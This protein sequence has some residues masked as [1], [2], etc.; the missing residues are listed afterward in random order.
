MNEYEHFFILVNPVP[1]N[2]HSS[3]IHVSLQ[4]GKGETVEEI[5]ENALLSD[6]NFRDLSGLYIGLNTAEKHGIKKVTV[7]TNN[8][9]LR[10]MVQSERKE[11]DSYGFSPDIKK[12][13][14]NF[15]EVGID[16]VRW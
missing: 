5:Q 16:V 6:N 3:S 1:L 2:G 12:L 4:D 14:G 10:A 7:L 13:I 11:M 9:F 8:V 15:E